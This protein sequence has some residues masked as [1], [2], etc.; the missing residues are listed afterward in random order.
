MAGRKPIRGI[1]HFGMTVPDLDAATR[2]FEQAFDAQ[3]LYDNIARADPP[4]PGEVGAGLVG[5]AAD[6]TLITMRMI[7]LG[8]GPGLELFEMRGPDRRPAARLSDVGLQHFAVYVDDLDLATERF[9]AAGGTMFSGP[10]DTDGHEKGAGHVWR[11]G[12]TPWGSLV[13]LICRPNAEEYEQHT[14]LRR[15]RPSA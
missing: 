13:E 3:V 4:F 7:Q 9:V 11:Y 14:P 15:W 1:D 2:F 12:R 8:N 6:A 10:N 5:M